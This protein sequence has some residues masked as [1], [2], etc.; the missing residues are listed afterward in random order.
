MS[1]QTY[2]KITSKITAKPLLKKFFENHNALAVKKY[3]DFYIM[4]LGSAILFRS[5]SVRTYTAVFSVGRRRGG[6]KGHRWGHEGRLLF[7]LT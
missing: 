4:P 6:V 7:D 2:V 3:L 1:N 5:P